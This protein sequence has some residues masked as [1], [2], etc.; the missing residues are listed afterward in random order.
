MHRSG[1]Q[2][3]TFPYSNF[4]AHDVVPFCFVLILFLKCF[5]LLGAW[6]C[7]YII[8]H[9]YNIYTHLHNDFPILES[10]DEN[11]FRPPKKLTPQV[12]L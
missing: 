12:R 4:P 10:D 2:P 7:I 11:C 1:R 3:E 8:K 9:F 5:Y 6:G